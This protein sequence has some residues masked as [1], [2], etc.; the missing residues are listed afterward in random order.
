MWPIFKLALVVYVGVF[1]VFLLGGVGLWTVLGATGVLGNFESFIG[2]LLG[3]EDFRFLGSRVF[4][5]FVL[6]G[7]LGVILS[8]VVTAGFALVYNLASRLVGG[9]EVDLDAS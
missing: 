7:L 9:L 3:Y 8:A 5:I 1:A 2:E 6:V 4:Q